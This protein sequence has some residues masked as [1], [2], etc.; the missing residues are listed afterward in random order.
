MNLLERI[1]ART[2]VPDERKR[3]QGIYEASYELVSRKYHEAVAIE[4]T[5]V[6]ASGSSGGIL[7]ISNPSCRLGSKQSNDDLYQCVKAVMDQL[8]EAKPIPLAPYEA[9]VGCIIAVWADQ[10]PATELEESRNDGLWAI[11]LEPPSP[12]TA[13]GG[14]LQPPSQEPISP[15]LHRGEQIATLEDLPAIFL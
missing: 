3:V 2:D 6:G 5:A 11:R 4:E 8:D 10:V 12:A 1:F 14:K 13:G 7:F 9:V 15:Y